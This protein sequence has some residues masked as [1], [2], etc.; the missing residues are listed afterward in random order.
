MASK[1][2]HRGRRAGREGWHCGHALQEC[3]V[4][5]Q[6]RTLLQR[7]SPSLWIVTARARGPTTLFQLAPMRRF[8]SGRN[9]KASQQGPCESGSGVKGGG[10]HSMACVQGSWEV[11]E[12]HAASEVQQGEEECAAGCTTTYRNEGAHDVLGLLLVTAGAQ[13]VLD[14]LRRRCTG[15]AQEPAA[16]LYLTCYA[17]PVP[18]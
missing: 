18:T 13:D 1:D 14:R 15:A 6:Q 7:P 5:L 4:G 8:C 3:G 9:T 11:D 12:K 17:P 10:T 16:S 2:S